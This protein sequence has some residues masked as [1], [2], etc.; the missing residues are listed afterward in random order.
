MTEHQ[1]NRE[2]SPLRSRFPMTSVASRTRRKSSS[3][4]SHAAGED[5]ASIY[6]SMCERF[7]MTP[8]PSVLVSLTTSVR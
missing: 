7:R 6:V 5:D 3:A 8:D 4:S 2:Q 1:K